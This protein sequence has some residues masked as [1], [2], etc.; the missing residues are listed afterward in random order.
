MEIQCIKYARAAAYGAYRN[1]RAWTV[2][3]YR[4]NLF[5][6]DGTPETVVFQGAVSYNR[7][8]SPPQGLTS[9]GLS[10]AGG[11]ACHRTHLPRIELAFDIFHDT[12]YIFRT[13]LG[14]T[15]N[16]PFT[17]FTRIAEHRDHKT[18]AH[19]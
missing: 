3:I 15:I 7:L 1:A 10:P 14:E 5:P 17:A 11:T 18:S 9:Y 2:D 19:T 13:C 16:S 6:L 12:L 4:I 8:L